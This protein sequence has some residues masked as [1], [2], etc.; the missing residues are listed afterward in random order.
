M[1]LESE[2]KLTELKSKIIHKNMN[3]DVHY[4][5]SGPAKHFHDDVNSYKDKFK[6]SS[7]K[8]KD[9]LDYFYAPYS[10]APY[11]HKTTLK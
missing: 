8:M 5:D 1:L 6:E 4:D 2:V 3:F 9:K 11:N 10:N 7:S